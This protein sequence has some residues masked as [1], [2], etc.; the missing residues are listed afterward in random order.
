MTMTDLGTLNGE[1]GEESEAVDINNA[2]RVIGYDENHPVTWYK[3]TM[4][5]INT[6]LP[7]NSG[8]KITTVEGINNHGQIVGQGT[9]DGGDTYTA[10]LLTP[11]WVTN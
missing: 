7:E 8:W 11:V 1:E 9:F 4:T 6:L 5:D 3:G 2:G 10:V